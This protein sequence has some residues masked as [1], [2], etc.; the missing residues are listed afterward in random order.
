MQTGLLE[1]DFGVPSWAVAI[2]DRKCFQL[3]SFRVPMFEIGC[4]LSFVVR[5]RWRVISDVLYR[6]ETRQSTDGL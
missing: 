6:L 5:I 4:C 1:F 2:T 3:V